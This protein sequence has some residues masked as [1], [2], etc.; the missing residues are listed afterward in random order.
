MTTK[1]A[2]APERAETTRRIQPAFDRGSRIAPRAGH[3]ATR[4]SSDQ[5]VLSIRASVRESEAD[6]FIADALRDIRVYMQEHHVQPAGPPFSICRPRGSEVDVEAGWPTAAPLNGTGRIHGGS[7]PRSLLPEVE[8]ARP[9]EGP[10]LDPGPGLGATRGRWER[11]LPLAL[12]ALLD[13]LVSV[14]LLGHRAHLLAS[15]CVGATLRCRRV[16]DASSC[17][18]QRARAGTRL[19]KG[20]TGLGKGPAKALCRATVVRR[21]RGGARRGSGGA[22]SSGNPWR[23]YGARRG[24]GGGRRAPAS[25]CGTRHTASACSE[26][27]GTAAGRRRSTCSR[28]GTRPRS[29]AAREPIGRAA[30]ARGCARPGRSAGLTPA[31]S[32]IVEAKSMFS[33]MWLSVWPQADCQG[34]RTTSGTR[35]DSS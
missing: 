9:R 1:T 7:V 15:V 35:I 23:D 12:L 25:R 2:P 6:R 18:A 4:A 21:A 17:T 13:L 19:R 29:R 34:T 26:A 30:A 28:P 10:R 20:L 24:R 33:T 16:V 5:P 14:V 32:E 3:V 22:R 27:P 8:P 31:S 11:P